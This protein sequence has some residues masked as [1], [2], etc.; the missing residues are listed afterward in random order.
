MQ[1]ITGFIKIV[2]LLLTFD[3]MYIESKLVDYMGTVKNIQSSDIKPKFI[4]LLAYIIMA[5]AIQNLTKTTKEAVV[6]GFVIYSIYNL[7]NYYIFTNWNINV[8]IPDTM[9]G[10]FLFGLVK[11]ISL[12]FST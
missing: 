1:N 8:A 3:L 5:Y 7:T 10:T 2:L 6:L 11:Y 9:W 12:G 4:G